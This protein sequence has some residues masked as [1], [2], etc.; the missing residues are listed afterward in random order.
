MLR[1]K[2]LEI[3][4]RLDEVVRVAERQ[5]MDRQTKLNK[6]TI[7]KAEMLQTLQHNELNDTVI[8]MSR[9]FEEEIQRLEA[10]VDDVPSVWLECRH[11][12]LEGG[13]KEMCRVCEGVSYVHRHTP[14]W[15]GVI[16][17]EGQNQISTPHVLVTDGDNGKVFL[18]EFSGNSIQV[19]DKDGN[20]QRSV[21]QEGMSL[22]VSIAITPHQ[23][24]VCE[25]LSRVHKLDKLSGSI[26][27]SVT[28]GSR[29]IC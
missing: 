20:Y 6:L 21:K 16:K 17:G 1:E 8:D 22:P 28:T 27:A 25:M 5:A 29:I 13:M 24:F 2:H 15:T 9:K 14:V 11:E 23:L 26:M 3:E 7:A 10:I 12:W 4:T 18:C 19:F